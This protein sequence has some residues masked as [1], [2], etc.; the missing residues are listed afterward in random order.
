MTR[1]T[2]Q[3]APSSAGFCTTPAPHRPVTRPYTHLGWPRQ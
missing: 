3:L 1:T 2:P